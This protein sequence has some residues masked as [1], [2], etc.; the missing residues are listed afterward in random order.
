MN[1]NYFCEHAIQR[2]K[3]GNY[4]EELPLLLFF[5]RVGTRV[6]DFYQTLSFCP[7]VKYQSKKER[8]GTKKMKDRKGNEA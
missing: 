7:K 3:R 2:I 5:C 1:L 6:H 8:G 4:L